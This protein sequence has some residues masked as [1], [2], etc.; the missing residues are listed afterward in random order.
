[1]LH[2]SAIAAARPGSVADSNLKAPGFGLLE[3]GVSNLLGALG[4]GGDWRDAELV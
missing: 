3:T 4:M 2:T 1:V